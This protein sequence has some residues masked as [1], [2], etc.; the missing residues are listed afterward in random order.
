MEPGS[1]CGTRSYLAAVEGEWADDRFRHEFELGNQT[2][3]S[4]TFATVQGPGYEV[5]A[6][7][8]ME[9]LKLFRRYL[10]GEW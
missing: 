10:D 1:E 8:P 9:A 7:K 3:A 6:F 2:D 4:F 5:P